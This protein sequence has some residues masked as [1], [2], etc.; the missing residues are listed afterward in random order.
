MRRGLVAPATPA[1]QFLPPPNMMAQG[2]PEAA[3]PPPT[4]RD[5][6]EFD[7]CFRTPMPARNLPL[8]PK[9]KRSAERHRE[10]SPAVNDRLSPAHGNARSRSLWQE[11]GK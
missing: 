2:A 1:T 6:L 3:W 8:G 7:N 4:R 10:T 5:S 11:T 9:T